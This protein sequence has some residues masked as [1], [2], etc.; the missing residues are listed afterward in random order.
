MAVGLL[1]RPLPQGSCT[2]SSCQCTQWGWGGHGSTCKMWIPPAGDRV[3]PG[4]EE[5][6]HLWLKQAE[7]CVGAAR[8][9]NP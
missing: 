2:L 4:M 8:G 7:A 6:E 5:K 1:G 9:G 3:E